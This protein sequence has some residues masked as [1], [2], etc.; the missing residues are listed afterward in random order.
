MYRNGIWRL[1][2]SLAVV[3]LACSLVLVA[4]SG[5]EIGVPGD[6]ETIQAAVNAASL[7]DTII[8]APGT[9]A[10]DPILIE[11]KT[12]L[13]LRSSDGADLTTILGMISVRNCSGLT[14]EGFT[15]SSP[16]KPGHGINVEC[17]DSETP[18]S[19]I[20]IK[21]NNIINCVGI[22]IV[23]WGQG[24]CPSFVI[25]G[26][27][28]SRNGFDGIRLYCCCAETI[29]RNNTITDNGR[30]N[31]RGCGI[32]LGSWCPVSVLIE[33]NVITGNAFANIHP[34]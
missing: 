16:G 26:N 3:L 31:A 11:G 23:C 14:I 28:I 17:T 9:Y 30:T 32:R 6:Y 4:V 8:V 24:Q 19:S 21:D 33:D 5:A 12:D 29:V 1:T 22:G 2:S 25:E 34:Q 27:D 20:V 10:E 7:G 18:G 13:T 15:I